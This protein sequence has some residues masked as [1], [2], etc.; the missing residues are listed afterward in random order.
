MIVPATDNSP[1]ITVH[2]PPAT[3]YAAR[4]AARRERIAALDRTHLLISNSRLVLACAGAILFWLAF[5]SAVAVAAVAGARV[6]RVRRAGR[7]ARAPVSANRSREERGALVRARSQSARRPLGRHRARRRRLSRRPHLRTTTSIC[8]AARRY[9]SCS[10]RRG[11]APERRRWR[12]GCEPARRLTRFRR[13]RPASRS[14]GRCSTSA[15]TS[16]SSPTSRPSAARGP[17]RP[18][19]RRRRRVSRARMRVALPS[20]PR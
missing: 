19:R 16:P 7:P 2:W 17:S 1:P 9:S 15:R 4:L 5:V 14:F 10:T 6:A 8:S 18:G 11:R 13:A 3:E 20:W 12:S